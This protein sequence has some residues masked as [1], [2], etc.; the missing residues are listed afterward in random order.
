MLTYADKNTVRMHVCMHLCMSVS[1]CMLACL[2]MYVRVCMHV[3]MAVSI[4][5]LSCGQRDESETEKE[6][7][8]F[9]LYSATTV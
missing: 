5:M 1:V 6:R 2:C 3:C 7:E 4:C 9:S 8:K